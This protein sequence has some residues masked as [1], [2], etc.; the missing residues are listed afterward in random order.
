MFDLISSHKSSSLKLQ[1]LTAF[2]S[3]GYLFTEALPKMLNDIRL[4]DLPLVLSL[5]L[6]LIIN[7]QTAAFTLLWLEYKY[8]CR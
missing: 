5:T 1:L 8:A 2:L 4:Y 6:S 7:L 3:Y